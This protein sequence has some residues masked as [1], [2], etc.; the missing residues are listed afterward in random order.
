MKKKLSPELVNTRSELAEQDFRPA[1]ALAKEVRDALG[2]C[3]LLWEDVN[4]CKEFLTKEPHKDF[5]RRTFV[6]NVFVFLE[7]SS[8]G[9]KRVA[10]HQSQN[11]EVDFSSADLA[12][13]QE[14]KYVLR[15][16]GDAVVQDKNFQ[17]FIP[18]LKFA[19]KCFAKAYGLEFS[20]NLGNVALQE[21]EA[22]RNRITHPK[23]LS[24]LSISDEDIKKTEAVCG[25][26]WEVIFPL[27]QEAN[28][29]I[30]SLR[31]SGSILPRRHPGKRVSDDS[32]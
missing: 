18:N 16:N 7:A 15:D 26:V 27:V 13:L 8:Y 10:L 29:K 31:N 25:W 22:L 30:I 32:T 19:L 11:F 1:E 5:W 21:F 4:L 24:E 20:L 6:R 3:Y 17:R 12:I 23:E 14:E 9:F 2:R 28:S